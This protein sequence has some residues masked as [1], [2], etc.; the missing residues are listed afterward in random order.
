[1]KIYDKTP[2]QQHF[3]SLAKFQTVV[4][5]RLIRGKAVLNPVRLYKMKQEGINQVIDLRN[6]SYVKRPLERFF[7]NVLGIKYENF[8]YSYRNKTMPSDDFFA[9][10]NESILENNGKTYI[11]C[12]HGKRRTGVCVAVYE[13]LYTDK[14][15]ED[16]ISNMVRIGFHE[17]K[18]TLGSKKEAKIKEM[19]NNLLDK[20][21][22]EMKKVE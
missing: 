2:V 15:D 3:G 8:R 5:N 6:T 11:H 1:M 18:E 19:F 12:Q 17:V 22:P 20:F 13:K 7:C 9:R 16:I 21:F 4:D 14:K 10:V